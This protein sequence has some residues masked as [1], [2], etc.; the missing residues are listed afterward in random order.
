M[1]NIGKIASRYQ[2]YTD[3]LNKYSWRFYLNLKVL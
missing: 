1:F 2:Y 3:K